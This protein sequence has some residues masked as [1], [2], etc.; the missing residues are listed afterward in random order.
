MFDTLFGQMPL[1]LKFFMVF[2]VILAVIAAIAWA[3]RR[4]GSGRLGATTRGRQ[5]RLAVIDYATVDSRRRLILVRRDNVEHLLMI[6]GPGDVVV[7]PNIVRATASPRD[8]ARGPAGIDA[9]PRAIPLPDSSASWPLQPES[10]G[11][12]RPRL[13]HYPD[14]SPGRSSPP[15]TPPRHRDT[16]AALADE[17]SSQPAT[18][19]VPLRGRPSITEPQRDHRSE[20]RLDPRRPAMQ[21]PVPPSAPPSVA[22]PPPA[23]GPAGAD[24]NLADMAQ[25]LEAALR[26]PNSDGRPPIASPRAIPMAE[27]AAR[28]DAPPPPPRLARAV[29]PRTEARPEPRPEPRPELR[30]EPRPE[31]RPELRSEPRAARPEAK[32]NQNKTAIY[33]TLEQEMANLLGRPSKS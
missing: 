3:L 17:L 20:P 25:R 18:P 11:A 28:A 5:P 22:G 6:G 21:A 26:K 27:A 15:E 8:M 32:P 16:L 30:P 31:L 4:F 7:E 10:N 14:D 23:D 1:A 24:Q 33:D 29:E 19:R 2:L 13:E 9:L 12:A